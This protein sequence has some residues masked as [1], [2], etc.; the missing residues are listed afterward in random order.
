MAIRSRARRSAVRL[1][2]QPPRYRFFLNP[3]TD[4]RFMTCPQCLGKTRQRKLPLVIH[5]EPLQLVA[6]NKT[7][8]YCPRCDLLI[9]HQDQLEAWL[10]AFFTEHRPE[11]V[12]NEYLVLG[13]EDRAD[14]L[15]GVH[16][17]VS[18]VK[19]FEQM[20]NFR[21]VVRFTPPQRWVKK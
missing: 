3:Y 8:R 7:C 5:I 18:P 6:L 2:K 9:A 1:G 10:A 15:R 17:P 14:W 11:I 16:T 12:G 13:T 21:E 4:V 19:A 20:H